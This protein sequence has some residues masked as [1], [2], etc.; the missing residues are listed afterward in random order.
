MSSKWLRIVEVAW[1]FVAAVSAVEI[2]ARWGNFNQTFYIFVLSLPV[3]V[4]MF[5]MR[6]KQRIK[7]HQR[8]MGK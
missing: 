1:L 2:Y 3:A 8:Q 6:R 5:W 4:F 7:Y